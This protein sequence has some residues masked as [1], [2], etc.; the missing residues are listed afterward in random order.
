[1]NFEFK[2]AT[3]DATK[4]RLAL[5]GYSGSGKT[6]TSLTVATLLDAGPIA[7]IDTE[8]GSASKYA[9]IFDFQTPGKLPNYDP[10]TFTA[11]IRACEKAGFG[12]IIIDSLSHAWMGKDGALEQASGRFDN[13]KNV[14]P[15]VQ[16]LVDQIVGSSAHVIATLRTKADIVI[17]KDSR[18]KTTI[19]KVGTKAVFKE[20]AEYEFDVVGDMDQDNVLRISKTRIPA[21]RGR[22][23]AQPGEEFVDIIRG[24]L[25]GDAP[26]E[27]VP[28][29]STEES[30]S[31][32]LEAEAARGD[33]DA[34]RA[35]YAKVQASSTLDADQKKTLMAQIAD[36][37]KAA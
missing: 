4:L 21:L 17:D 19:E 10:D 20:G 36:A 11:A 8:H 6:W 9:D 5:A 7:V 34:L 18:G 31:L 28:E 14:T 23:F 27:A 22:S 15:K 26:G 33:K 32:A 13:W 3:K 1:M 29:V 25:T 24:W 37:G 16:R 30:M 2:K 35:V 12:V